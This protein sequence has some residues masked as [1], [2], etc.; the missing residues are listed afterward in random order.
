VQVPAAVP[1]IRVEFAQVKLGTSLFVRVMLLLNMPESVAV[2]FTTPVVLGWTQL[3]AVTVE[4][5][6][7]T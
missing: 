5:Q 3:L 1:P 7:T 6:A 2:T 4:V